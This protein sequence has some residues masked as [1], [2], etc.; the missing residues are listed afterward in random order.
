MSAFVTVNGDTAV[1]AVISI[2]RAG[3]W[4]ADINLNA[5]SAAALGAATISI[6]DG[7]MT[8][9]GYVF[10]FGVF[11]DYVRLRIVGGNGTLRTTQLPAKAYQ[12]IP[13]R[14][15]FTD[16]LT[17]AG[18]TLS[19]S[20]DQ[21][22]LSTYL[23]PWSTIAGGQRGIG[24]ALTSLLRAAPLGPLGQP[25]NWRMAST[26]TPAGIT[27]DGSVWVGYESWPVS[28]I[29]EFQDYV[30]ELDDAT[31]GKVQIAPDLPLLLPGTVFRRTGTPDRQVTYVRHQVEASKHLRTIAYYEA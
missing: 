11:S 30:Y 17:Q 9:K 7:A 16:I 8:M 22:L 24:G 12:G 14:V 18:E 20:S 15:A 13:F 19:P 29:Q 25:P 28:P 1:D 2:P 21:G 10:R 27:F 26:V 3:G 4:H 23:G 31:V 6:A 5:G